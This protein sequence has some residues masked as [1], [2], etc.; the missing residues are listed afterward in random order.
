MLGNG[1]Y[2]LKTQIIHSHTN[3]AINSHMCNQSNRAD[4]ENT[5]E[6]VSCRQEWQREVK[7]AS[8]AM[9]KDMDSQ[10]DY[11]LLVGRQTTQQTIA[12][13]ISL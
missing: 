12:M 11:A 5:E 2:V 1:I 3:V 10:F 7:R 9:S 13:W 6:S 8:I 4:K